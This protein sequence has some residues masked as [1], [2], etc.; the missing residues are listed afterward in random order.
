MLPRNIKHHISFYWAGGS[1]EGWPL[2]NC[3]GYTKFVSLG[4]SEEKKGD[5]KEY[6]QNYLQERGEN[7]LPNFFFF[8]AI[9]YYS[10]ED[11]LKTELYQCH[12]N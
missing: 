2:Q 6:R 11:K 8:L 9:L 7:E 4:D 5:K 12:L 1:G 10:K 3:C